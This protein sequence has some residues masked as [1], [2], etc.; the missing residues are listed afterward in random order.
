MHYVASTTYRKATGRLYFGARYSHWKLQMSKSQ[1][2]NAILDALPPNEREAISPNLKSVSLKA[3]EALS[4]PGERLAYVHFPTGSLVSI[5]TVMRD[6][7]GIE[8]GAIGREGFV[9]THLVW[10][11][12][13]AT[14]H[15]MCQI[16]GDSACI[17]TE[18][19]L[20]LVKKTRVLRP[21]MQ[22]HANAVNF[23]MAQSIACNRLHALTQR[24]ARWLL[25]THDRVGSDEFLLTQ[26]FLAVM[27]GVNRQSVSVTASA[28]QKGGLIKYSRGHLIIVDRKGLKSAACECY[29]VVADQ[30]K[31]LTT[32]PRA[33]SSS[34]IF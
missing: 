23:S 31:R 32:I 1:T 22:R 7:T 34:S 16:A 27:L 2:G 25:L 17:R 18:T 26:E 5:V 24:C 15:T 4:R 19:L 3:G 9:G 29:Q 12:D 21:L 20:S 14:H 30:Y 11:T 13:R 8:I 28:L 33:S 10:G 6:G